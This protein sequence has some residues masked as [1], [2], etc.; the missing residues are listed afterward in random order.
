MQ[1]MSSGSRTTNITMFEEDKRADM[2][3]TK[4]NDDHFGTDVL[5][6]HRME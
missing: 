2:Q 6:V 1:A 3:E 5:S 4:G